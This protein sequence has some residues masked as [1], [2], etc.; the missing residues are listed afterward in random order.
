MTKSTKVL[1]KKQIR[2]G[3]H[4]KT[5]EDQIWKF[6]THL[7]NRE[8]YWGREIFTTPTNHIR[9]HYVQEES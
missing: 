6:I 1:T 7:L 3:E 9:K 4:K 2:L 8:D 5:P